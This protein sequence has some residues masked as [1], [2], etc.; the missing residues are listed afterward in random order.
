MAL[1]EVSFASFNERDT[2][3]GWV[4]VPITKPKAIV[5][6]VHG[7]GE[8]SRR[9][10]HMIVKFLDAGFAV[11]AD[12]HVGHGKTAHDSGTWGDL[13]VKGYMTTVNDEHTLRALVTADYPGV[14]YF[15]Y[16][17]SWGSIIARNYAAHYA[18]GMAGLIICGSPADSANF[19]LIEDAAR[20]YIEQGKDNEIVPELIGMAFAG[21]TDR[22]D[23]PKSPSDWVAADENVVADHDVDP[24]NNLTSP[25]NARMVYDFGQATR[26]IV[27]EEWAK[28]LP[29]SLPIY[30]IGGDMDPVAA[31]GEGIYKI[32]RWLYD[33]GHRNVTTKV[34]SGYRHEIH[35]E[36]PIR[37]EVEA[38]IISFVE[39]CVAP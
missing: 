39:R 37:D 14:P 21:F 19:M 5:Q 10:L 25:P 6:I 8:H 4:Y 7:L 36:P 38:G 11:C 12:D 20:P 33:T 24:F 23:N 18:D 35:N 9:Y 34:Y 31:Y 27:G 15:M 16:G 26:M 2:V 32:T 17:H 22:Y 13:G 3:K 1:K 29:A 30:N 28:K